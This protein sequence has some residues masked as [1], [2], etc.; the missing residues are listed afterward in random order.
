MKYQNKLSKTGDKNKCISDDIGNTVLNQ[1][2]FQITQTKE[3]YEI[4]V[5]TKNTNTFYSTWNRN[6]QA[7][8]ILLVD[9][10][11]FSL[12]ERGHEVHKR[13]YGHGTKE[14]GKCNTIRPMFNKGKQ[15]N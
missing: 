12:G 4:P 2:H 13:E 14:V 8:N 6:T 15:I 9:M 1:N 11:M 10:L 5:S 7:G 3:R